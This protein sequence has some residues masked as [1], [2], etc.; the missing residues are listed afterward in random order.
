MRPSTPPTEPTSGPSGP[1]SPLGTKGKARVALT[2]L[3]AN[4]AFLESFG[5]PL[6]P[7]DC[8]TGGCKKP[9]SQHNNPGS[10]EPLAIECTDWPL[11]DDLQQPSDLLSTTSP[12]PTD[13]PQLN[14]LHA[15]VAAQQAKPL[16]FVGF[17]DAPPMAT[18]TDSSKQP[19][20][21]D[22]APGDEES[23]SEGLLILS[24]NCRKTSAFL[25]PKCNLLD[26]EQPWLPKGDAPPLAK[27]VGPDEEDV[28]DA[29]PW[30]NIPLPQCDDD[31]M[32]QPAVAAVPAPGLMVLGHAPPAA[33]GAARAHQLAQLQRLL[34]LP[35]F[36]IRKAP[37]I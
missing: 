20:P 10:E 29:V 7:L 37:S 23:L 18:A 33:P 15:P 17:A 22:D 34:D 1:I 11:R 28:D 3:A 9:P 26:P 14:V 27:P 6:G 25:P 31:E 30:L 24:A 32:A 13:M 5:V 36:T 16:N 35:S 21:H 8:V 19:F 4:V 12:L 2:P